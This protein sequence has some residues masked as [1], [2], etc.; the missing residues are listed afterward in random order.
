MDTK[1]KVTGHSLN[2]TAMLADSKLSTKKD[3]PAFQKI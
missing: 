1:S 3:D 2:K